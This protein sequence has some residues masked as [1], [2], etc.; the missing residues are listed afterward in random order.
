MSNIKFLS[1]DL[2]TPWVDGTE[3]PAG[4][5]E[6]D[7]NGHPIAAIV[8]PL[9][10]WNEVVATSGTFI[11]GGAPNNRFGVPGNRWLDLS[12]GKGYIKQTR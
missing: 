12:N 4:L 1:N 10:T 7:A 6:G 3:T 8:P 5:Y 11:R 2:A 9:E